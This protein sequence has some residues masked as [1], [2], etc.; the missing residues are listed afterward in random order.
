MTVRVYRGANVAVMVRSALIKTEHV[1]LEPHAS[2]PVPDQPV[3]CESE[4]AVAVRVTEVP[5]SK[6]ALHPVGEAHAI[7]SGAEFTVPL[8]E[9]ANAT[10][11]VR[12]L[13]VAVT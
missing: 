4:D 10:V 13:N 3:N 1:V 7:P 8:P 2:A 5:L 11:S 12:E 6:V 9:P